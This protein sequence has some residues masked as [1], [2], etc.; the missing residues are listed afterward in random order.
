MLTEADILDALR[1]CYDPETRLDL[2]ELGMVAGIDLTVDETAPGAGIEGVAVRQQLALRLLATGE[3]E[4]KW[5][6]MKAQVGNRLGGVEGLSRVWVEMVDGW[7]AARITVK[8]RRLL[9]L[10]AGPFRVLNNRVR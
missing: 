9:G 2:V 5:A 6:T 7:T 8:G 10:E 3:D 4:E 1:S